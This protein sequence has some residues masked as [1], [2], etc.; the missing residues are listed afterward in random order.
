MLDEA[1]GEVEAEDL[2]ELDIAGEDIRRKLIARVA[3]ETIECLASI[4]WPSFP[5]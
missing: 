3:P 5:Q 1:D 4:K 2:V